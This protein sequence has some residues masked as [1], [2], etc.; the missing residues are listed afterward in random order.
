MVIS[1]V[2][3]LCGGY[4]GKECVEQINKLGIKGIEVEY[5]DD[6]EAAQRI[7]KGEADY[8]VGTCSTGSA[9]MAIIRALLGLDKTAMISVLGKT[10]MKEAD[11]RKALKDGV[12][13]FGIHAGGVDNV[14]LELIK[15]IKEEIGL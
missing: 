8:Y 12:I 10:L 13:A 9:S 11:V 2:K 3:I 1:L 6:M 7:L 4:A 14:L 15:I 5:A